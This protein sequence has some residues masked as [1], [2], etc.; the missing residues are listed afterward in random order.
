MKTISRSTD[1]AVRPSPSV[2]A[3]VYPRG[4][5]A[6]GND[7]NMWEI[8]VDSRGTHRWKKLASGAGIYQATSPSPAMKPKA[9]LS[10]IETMVQK[11]LEGARLLM[12]DDPS[13]KED[14]MASLEKKME[15]YDL[16][17]YDE[18]EYSKAAK[19]IHDFLRE[20][21]KEGGKIALKQK[22]KE[23]FESALE[24][25]NRPENQKHLEERLK[26]L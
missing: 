1:A 18:P 20:K 4:Y 2:S 15:G 23:L 9:Q 6:R 7:G 14:I 8:I 22:K 21:F 12:E 17:G 11:Q 19:M 26:N 5:R 16:L 25:T 24:S 10:N 13:L 3:T